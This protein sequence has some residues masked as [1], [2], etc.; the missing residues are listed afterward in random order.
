MFRFASIGWLWALVGIAG[1]IILFAFAD[2]RK[3]KLLSRFGEL[4][5]VQNLL[6][7][8][9]PTRRRWKRFFIIL[10]YS[11][12]VLAL[13]RP[14]LGTKLEKVERKG[15][16]LMVCLDLSNSMYAED[17]KPNRFIRARSEL[18]N[19]INSLKG[20]RIGIV[21]FAGDAFLLCPLTT[22][23]DAASMLLESVNPHSFPEQGTNIPKALTLAETAFIDKQRK[24]KAILLITDGESH[25]GETDKIVNQLADKGIR[26]YTVGVGN[27]SGVPIPLRDNTGRI[28]GYKKDQNGEVVTTSLDEIGLQKIALKTGGRYFRATAGQEELSAIFKEI[29]GMEKKRIT[30]ERFAHFEDRFQYPLALAFLFL[31]GE[32]LTPERK[33]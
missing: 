26:I 11:F 6:D 7:K 13:A 16:D 9:L 21:V 17:V 4:S 23:Y 8:F 5:L 33:R 29:E 28:T 14:Q 32:A 31:L 24:Y 25:E 12:L 27:P 15:I 30:I 1:L 20:D 19:F 3:K 10:S 18:Q 2:A 22:D